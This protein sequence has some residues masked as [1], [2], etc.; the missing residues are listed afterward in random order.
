M[1]GSTAP[2]RVLMTADTVG[3]VWIYCLELAAALGRRGLTVGIAT[4]G[5]PPSDEQYAQAALLP[6]VELFESSFRLE[7]M[8]EPW[9][10]VDD[11]GDWLLHVAQA[12]GPD[13]VHLNNYCHGGLPW[14]A[15]ATRPP[16]VA[17]MRAR[18]RMV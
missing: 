5:P 9:D 18:R 11:A 16:W 12:F 15:P 1:T 10:D 8:E 17:W 6:S 7:W 2:R 3:G 14:N 4:M 13:V